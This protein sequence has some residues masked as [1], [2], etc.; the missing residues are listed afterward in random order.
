MALVRRYAHLSPS[1]LQE[2]LER[3]SNFGKS[4]GTVTEF[5]NG[6]GVEEQPIHKP[7]ENMVAIESR[8]D[9]LLRRKNV[10]AG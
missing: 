6:Q 3:L 5:G 2:Q 4:V 10:V 8:S 9:T 7:A 1:H